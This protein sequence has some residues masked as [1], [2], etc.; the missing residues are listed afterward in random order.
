MYTE[1]IEY[2]SCRPGPDSIPN[3]C[4]R[5]L[6]EEGLNYI[7]RLFN[8]ILRREETP[9]SWSKTY[10]FFIFKKG[11]PLLPENYRGISLLNSITKVFTQLLHNRITNWAE[12][13]NPLSEVQNGFRSGRGC[14]DNLFVLHSI[15]NL[16]LQKKR[17]KL[18][19]GLTTS[20]E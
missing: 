14:L 1:I 6:P 15:S 5:Y 10:T 19:C 7:L 11:D 20:L 2:C 16:Y 3:E 9:T 17:G 12:Y 18:Y 4:L 13:C 8:V